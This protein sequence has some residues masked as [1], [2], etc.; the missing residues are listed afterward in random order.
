[1]EHENDAGNIERKKV[2]KG[3]YKIY[4]V[5]LFVENSK[6]KENI[7]FPLFGNY[8]KKIKKNRSKN[9]KKNPINFSQL[10][11]LKID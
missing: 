8:I 9:V 5:F 6:E 4:L 1:M 3:K 2:R 11:P 10:I 7:H